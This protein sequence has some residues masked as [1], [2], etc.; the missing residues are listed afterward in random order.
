M[1][2]GYL[3]LSA[4]LALSLIEHHSLSEDLEKTALLLSQC[5]DESASV[6]AKVVVK[7]PELELKE[8]LR[9]N[10][11]STAECAY[12]DSNGIVVKPCM[13]RRL[14]EGQIPAGEIAEDYYP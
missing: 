7:T 9:R 3:I 6:K 10:G 14:K 12:E 5:R 2:A 4:L 8:C 13:G 1:V 11:Y